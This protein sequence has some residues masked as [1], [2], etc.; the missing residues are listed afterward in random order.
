M[1]QISLNMW[2]RV[3][4]SMQ[5][6]F[7]Q[8]CGEIKWIQNMILSDKEHIIT[9]WARTWTRILQYEALIRRPKYLFVSDVSD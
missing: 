8:Q 3:P 4:I 7:H 1:L 2:K 6:M 5:M 9:V